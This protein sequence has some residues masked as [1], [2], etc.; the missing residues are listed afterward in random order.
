MPLTDVPLSSQTLAE[1]QPTI[2]S[3]FATINT[4]FSVDHVPYVDGGQG[5]H[6][7]VTF[8]DNTDVIPNV[9]GELTLF[10]KTTTLTG[11]PDV[12]MQRGSVALGTKNPIPI[13]G[14]L[15]ATNGWSYL[16]SGLLIKWG[17]DTKARNTLSTITFPTG[18]N[19][20]DFSSIFMVQVSQ[21]FGAGPSTSDLNTAVSAGN[22]T[23]A[24]FQVFPR[25]IGLPNGSTVNIFY[26]AIGN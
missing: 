3:N 24:N 16:P 25:A 4:A 8:P 1:T 12:W 20:P 9:A 18:A 10:N 5:K 23:I 26:Y 17:I 19:I 6:K 7:K 22:I 2:R 21:T 13:T 14:S 15:Q 11:I